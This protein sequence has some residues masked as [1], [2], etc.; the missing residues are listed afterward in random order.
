MNR[1]SIVNVMSASVS[2]VVAIILLCFFDKLWAVPLSIAIAMFSGWY[3]S[4]HFQKE[5]KALSW[6]VFASGAIVVAIFLLSPKTYR[7]APFYSMAAA[8]PFAFFVGAGLRRPATYGTFGTLALLWLGW[9]A[10]FAQSA[11]NFVNPQ[12]A[13]LFGHVLIY[14]A[15]GFLLQRR[16]QDGA[17]QLLLIAPILIV[18][19][20]ENVTDP[21]PESWYLHIVMPAVAVASW[22]L[23]ILAASRGLL[24]KLPLL[25]FATTVVGVAFFILPAA[26]ER[27]RWASQI[28]ND[29]IPPF[30]LVGLKGDSLNNDLV[31]GK[32]L[33]LDFY[34]TRCSPCVR[35]MASL[36]K[37]S[38]SF[39]GNTHVKFVT[40]S[41]VYYESFDAFL[42]ADNF[43]KFD[44]WHGYDEDTTLAARY[45]P[46][47]V[48]VGLLID[49]HGRV[50]FKKEGFGERDATY[51][52][53]DLKS[54]IEGL[55]AEQ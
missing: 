16:S 29:V 33:W 52:E 21:G 3:A 6:M 19:I 12:Y 7:N 41:S 31:Q 42:K 45:A 23:G 54:K 38:N 10:I 44:L 9:V 22:G 30:Q 14:S 28:E 34:T 24:A 25:G 2:I 49:K 32:V 8:V 55:L 11:F 27:G 43:H 51:F 26:L 37:V 48:P 1:I 20:I 15:G 47:G 36:E 5:I 40:I 39:K 17:R 18:A 50:R 4:P 46:S 53:A 35:E 13:G